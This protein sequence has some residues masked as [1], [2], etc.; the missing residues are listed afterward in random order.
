[1]MERFEPKSMKV[2]QAPT[3]TAVL[4]NGTAYFSGVVANDPVTGEMRYGTIEEETRLVI[5]RM[6]LM[7]ADLGRDLSHVV[8]T[9]VFLSTMKDFDGFN[10]VYK[11]YFADLPC[12]A[13]RRTV[14]VELW[15]DC[16]IEISFF[17]D[18]AE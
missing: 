3:A 16:K 14:G 9:E 10:K 17:A 7:L 18:V 11:E 13:A 8:M 6:K 1:M 12:P 2:L 5:E 15:E 4:C